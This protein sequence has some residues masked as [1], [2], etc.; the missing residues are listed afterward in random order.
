MEDGE[1][2]VYS[3][4]PEGR[5]QRDRPTASTNLTTVTPAK[6][7]ML[8]SKRESGIDT[9]ADEESEA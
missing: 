4:V 5:W 7:A 3:L 1:K 6:L 2:E 9:E 8:L